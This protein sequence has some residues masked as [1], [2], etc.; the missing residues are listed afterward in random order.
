MKIIYLEV[1]KDKFVFG[2]YLLA[3]ILEN[4]VIVPVIVH[5]FPDVIVPVIDNIS[6]EKKLSK[7]KYFFC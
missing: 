2:R 4:F 6:T 5:N 7:L 3:F 1:G